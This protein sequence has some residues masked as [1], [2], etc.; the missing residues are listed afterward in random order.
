M[1]HIF[2]L[3]GRF[4]PLVVHLPI[5]I[6][7]LAVA[8]EFLALKRKFSF[9]VPVLPLIWGAGFAGAVI[10]CIA[11]WFLQL[12]GEYEESAV[13]FHQN[14]GIALAIIT[15]ILFYLKVKNNHNKIH[16]PVAIGT[17]VLLGLT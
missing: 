10:A 15:G 14:F 4:H 13:F 6:I 3:I 16:F 11:G 9:I 8:L 12:S 17:G 1:E 2:Q 5:G 7:F